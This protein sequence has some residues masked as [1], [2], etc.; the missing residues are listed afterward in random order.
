V[1]VKL[2]Y[3]L[4]WGYRPALPPRAIEAVRIIKPLDS[5]EFHECDEADEAHGCC[6]R[7]HRFMRS[8]VEV[9]A[10]ATARVSGLAAWLG[11]ETFPEAEKEAE[12][13]DS[14]RDENRAT[15]GP[16]ESIDVFTIVDFPNPGVVL[17]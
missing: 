4:S 14:W 2:Q 12:F 7:A 17:L 11:E 3:R 10:A 13:Q 8:G 9:V 16:H 5:V 6:H 1:S 15:V